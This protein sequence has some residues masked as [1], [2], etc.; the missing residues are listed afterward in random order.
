[1][2]ERRKEFKL[3]IR[4]FSYFGINSA[5][6]SQPEPFFEQLFKEYHHIEPQFTSKSSFSKNFIKDS[7]DV[8]ILNSPDN[9]ND[10]IKTINSISKKNNSIVIIPQI[11]ASK[12][13]LNIWEDFKRHDMTRV[14][15]E[16]Y[17]FGLIFFR[18][19]NSIEHF[20]IRF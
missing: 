6:I 2:K 9:K 14:S 1:M 11:R 12:E 7:F 17:H 20:K 16:F 4:L 18:I 3:Y 10:T 5:F 15:L 13:Q 8:F 19:E